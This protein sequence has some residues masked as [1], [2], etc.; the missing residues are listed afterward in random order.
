MFGE[1]EHDSLKYKTKKK[2]SRIRNRYGGKV[3]VLCIL[4]FLVCGKCI[5]WIFCFVFCLTL[6]MWIR[7]SFDSLEVKTRRKCVSKHFLSVV[8]LKNFNQTTPPKKKK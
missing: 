6:G 7:F 8:Y 4:C 3:D 5:F 2:S 1:E